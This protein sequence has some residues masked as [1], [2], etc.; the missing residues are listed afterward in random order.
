MSIV[1]GNV[2]TF[3]SGAGALTVTVPS[4]IAQ[5]DLLLLLIMSA[6]QTIATPT[7][8]TG[9]WTQIGDQTN[10]GTGTAG[11]A[12][13]VR[14]AVY[15]K[16]ATS[17][18]ASASVS[19]SG[20]INVAQMIAFNGV[21]IANPFNANA[22]NILTPGNASLSM[23]AVTTTIPYTVI[24]NA[25]ANDRDANNSN[26]FGTTFSNTNLTNVVKKIDQTVNTATGGGLA[27]WTGYLSDATSSG[28]STATNGAA[29]TIG[30]LTMALRPRKRGVIGT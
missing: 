23:P 25:V 5:D 1:V 27:C 24:V 4:G 21:D 2:G 20:D 7:T 30:Y 16:F 14:L 19:D 11:A 12:G 13:G 6:N 15:Y 10:Q 8:T 18:E 26:N 3:Q 9:T 22:S 28:N 17:A 29:V